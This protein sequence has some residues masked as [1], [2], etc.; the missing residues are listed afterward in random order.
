MGRELQKLMR[1]PSLTNVVE[2]LIVEKYEQA[3]TGNT[4]PTQ[5]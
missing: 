1:R 4:T 3:F 5:S 2:V